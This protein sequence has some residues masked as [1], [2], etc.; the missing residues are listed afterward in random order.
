MHKLHSV[1][2]I[3]QVDADH[4]DVRQTAKHSARVNIVPIAKKKNYAYR[5]KKKQHFIRNIIRPIWYHLSNDV[6]H[7]GIIDL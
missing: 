2:S 4:T 6:Q 3:P 5:M 1:S 7:I